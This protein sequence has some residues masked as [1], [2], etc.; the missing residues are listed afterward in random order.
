MIEFTRLPDIGTVVILDDQEF[1]LQ[2]IV[3]PQ[4]A[5]GSMTELLLW[6]SL[7]AT[8]GQPYETKT[9]VRTSGISRRCALH[10]KP[11]KPVKGKRGRKVKI[12]VILP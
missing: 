3:P 5:D 12:Q 1:E 2:R 6:E 9:T 7:C 4:K 8:C 11:G 10:S